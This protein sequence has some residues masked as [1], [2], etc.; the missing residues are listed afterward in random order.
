MKDDIKGID[1]DVVTL[2]EEIKKLDASVALATVNRKKEHTEFTEAITLNEAA[3][4]LIEKAKNR[5]AKFYNPAIY[6]EEPKKELSAQDRIVSN[7]GGT[8]DE[9]PVLLQLVRKVSKKV[10]PPE[11]PETWGAYKPAGGQSGGIMGLMDMLVGE[12]KSDMAE[13]KHDEQM[14]QKEYDELMVDSKDTRKQ[15][16]KSIVD[17]QATKANLEGK[18]EET[19]EKLA[20]TSEE[21]MNVSTQLGDLHS[22]CDFIMQNFDLRREARNNEVESLKNA[23]AVLAGANFGF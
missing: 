13:A 23:K 1:D 8:V 15:N 9:A 3:I 6:K 16:A 20:M 10:A 22:S 21:L 17:K 19:K 12:L 11:T 4:Q 2:E 18:L 7:L 5:L 14:A